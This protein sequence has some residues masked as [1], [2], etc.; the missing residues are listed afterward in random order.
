MAFYVGCYLCVWSGEEVHRSLP[1]IFS[2]VYL[3]SPISWQQNT[4]CSLQWVS[5]Q[6]TWFL[7]TA[8]STNI[9]PCC[10]RTTAQYKVLRDCPDHTHQYGLRWKHGSS[11]SIWSRVPAA[12]LTNFNVVSGCR[13]TID[14]HIAIYSNTC[15]RYHPSPSTARSSGTWWAPWLAHPRCCLFDAHCPGSLI[16]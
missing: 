4:P 11:T 7:A 14:I 6:I 10:S 15:Y 16:H 13:T 2:I 12:W 3:Q 5:A 1:C 8:Q 9:V